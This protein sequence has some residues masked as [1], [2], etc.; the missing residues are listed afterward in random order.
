MTDALRRACA[1]AVHVVTARGE[2]IRAGRAALHVLDRIGFRRTAAV[3]SIPPLVWLVELGY[4]IVA[5]N[6]SFFGR[7][8]F[9]R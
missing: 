4:R 9:T 2:V 1:H 8:P 3:L 5:R 7:F 6:R